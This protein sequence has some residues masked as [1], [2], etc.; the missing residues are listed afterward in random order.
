MLRLW[1]VAV[2]NP[3]QVS[4]Q[5]GIPGDIPTILSNVPE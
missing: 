3:T 5:K 2:G 4:L 1:K